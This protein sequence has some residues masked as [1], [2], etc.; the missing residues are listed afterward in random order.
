MSPF[1][2]KCKIMFQTCNF[3]CDF[4]VSSF[5]L[6]VNIIFFSSCP[7]NEK[8]YLK[9]EKLKCKAHPIWNY[10]K[11]CKDDLRRA[12]C[13]FC[14]RK[15]SLGSDVIEKQTLSSMQHHVKTQHK[16]PIVLVEKLKKSN[17]GPNS[18]CSQNQITFVD[19]GQE[20][21]TCHHCQKVL[22]SKNSLERHLLAH[23]GE[24]PFNCEHC[25]ISFSQKS[26]LKAHIKSIHGK[27]AFQ[28]FC[29]TQLQN[30]TKR[31]SLDSISETSNSEIS[32]NSE[33][34]LNPKPYH[35][36]LNYIILDQIKILW[37]F[38]YNIN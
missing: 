14:F 22:S 35:A 3:S 19:K 38:I 31:T 25:A 21:Y 5:L 34:Q 26:N 1:F 15:I 16:Q 33:S 30:S 12:A 7:K 18:I 4:L 8:C 9:E 37:Y 17:P 13:K 20:T 29:K 36:E 2:A 28:N 24:K 6:D 10:F 11:P 27:I 32:L 23:T